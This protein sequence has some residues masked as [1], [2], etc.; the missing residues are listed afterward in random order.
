MK[1]GDKVIMNQKYPVEK[2]NW[3]KIWVVS[4]APCAVG[5][6]VVVILRGREEPYPVDGLE[7]IPGIE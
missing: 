5:D 3:F 6:Q 1:A 7:L 2:E 4:S